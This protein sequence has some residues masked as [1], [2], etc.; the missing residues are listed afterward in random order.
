MEQARIDEILSRIRTVRIAVYGDLC[1]DIYWTMLPKGSEISVETGNRAEAVEKHY[2]SPGGASNVLANVAALQ[3]VDVVALG[4]IGDDIH[5]RELVK[6]FNEK[7]INTEHLTI[8]KNHFD[9]YAF[10]KKYF[11]EVEVSRT[12]FGIFNKKSAE[13]DR[14]ILHN[15]R[16]ALENCNVL[17][18][19]QQIPDS[20]IDPEFL[21]EVQ[22]L[23]K[24]YPE[25]PVVVDTR[26]LKDLFTGVYYKANG[27]EIAMLDGVTDPGTNLADEVMEQHAI[28]VSKK[29][30]KPVF[31]TMGANGMMV[32][33]SDNITKLPSIQLSGS[34]DTVGAGDTVISALALCLAINVDPLDAAQFANL[35]AGVT[36]QKLRTTGTA[37]GDEILALNQHVL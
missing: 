24:A 1:L 14:E 8:Q 26:H 21:V 34:S 10:T 5:G 9:T 18:F 13:T 37:T 4:V 19:N 25:R 11:E 20:I 22:K 3:P 28:S 6:Q 7:S 32:V 36:V 15:I 31:V 35:A 12:D 27:T 23:F 30:N 17:I 29:T 33:D 2:Y 16:F